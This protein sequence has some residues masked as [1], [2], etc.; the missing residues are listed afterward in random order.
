MTFELSAADASRPVDQKGNTATATPAAGSPG[1]LRDNP[2]YNGLKI[3]NFP[4]VTVHQLEHRPP[5]KARKTY[6]KG[7]RLLEKGQLSE[8]ITWLGEAVA[9]DPE[10]SE[11]HNDLAAAY[12]RAGRPD[13][14]IPLLKSTIDVDPHWG[15]AYFNLAVAYLSLNEL[16]QAECTARRMAKIDAGSAQAGLVLGLSLTVE[17]KFTLEAQAALTQAEPVFPE[18]SLL[19]ARILAG[20]GEIQAAKLKISTYLASPAMWGRE[21]ANEWLALLDKK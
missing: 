2:T 19:L 15:L 1:P 16:S 3:D 14:A 7:R 13:Q 4:I 21:M 11:A 6:G 5:S 20:R 8:A 18:A 12:I 10:Y 9:I 17:N